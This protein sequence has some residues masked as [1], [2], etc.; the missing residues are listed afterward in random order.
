MNKQKAPTGKMP[1]PFY[2]LAVALALGFAS[3]LL[4]L[5]CGGLFSP[6]V[7]LSQSP[8]L[9]AVCV[10]MLAYYTDKPREK[11]F[12]AAFVLFEVYFAVVLAVSGIVAVLPLAA[13]FV[14]SFCAKNRFENKKLSG[15]FAIAA[16]AASLA[17]AVTIAITHFPSLSGET[18]I[19]VRLFYGDSAFSNVG[20]ILFAL[21]PVLFFVSVLVHIVKS[22]K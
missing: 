15:I 4:C 17:S 11:F 6:L 12:F 3:A 1:A 20:Y 18:H 8:A 13:S 16:V 7:P 9:L 19:M 22:E 14:L 2:I 21:V 5:V 10:V